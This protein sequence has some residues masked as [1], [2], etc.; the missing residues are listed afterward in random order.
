MTCSTSYASYNTALFAARPHCWLEFTFLITKTS[1]SFQHS[2]ISGC[3]FCKDFFLTRCKT[4]CFYSL[5]FLEFKPADFSSLSRFGLAALPSHYSLVPSS[6]LSSSNL[7][8]TPSN[9]CF[10]SLMKMINRR[11][12]MYRTCIASLV[13]SLQ[14]ENDPLFIIK[15]S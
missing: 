14:V 10:R 4:A 2:W 15:S 8:R 3:V 5:D 11:G 6:L 9:I 1:K 12:F 13:T 7:A